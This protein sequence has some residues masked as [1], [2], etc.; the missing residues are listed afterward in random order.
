MLLM[1]NPKVPPV[2]KGELKRV[3]AEAAKVEE[4]RAKKGD[5][6]KFE[7][8]GK[9][10]FADPQGFAQECFFY[11]EGNGPAP[12]QL[13]ILGAIPEKKRVAV[14][15]GHGAGKCEAARAEIPLADGRVVKASDLVGK[16]FEIMA[17]AK[18]GSQYP[19]LAWA[20]DN[21]VE[22]VYRVVTEC[23]REILRTGNHPL[24][25][26]TLARGHGTTKWKKDR[27]TPAPSGFRP[28]SD[29]APGDLVAVPLHLHSVGNKPCPLDEVKLLGYLLGD[30]GT[31]SGVTFTQEEG[32]AKE[33][34]REIVGRLGSKCNE[35]TNVTIDVTKGHYSPKPNSVLTMVRF[36]GLIGKKS[37]DKRFP[38]WAWELPNSQLSVLLNR[39]FACDGWAYTRQEGKRGTSNIAIS[40]ASEGLIRD[41]ELALLRLGI[42]G[43]VR[44]RLVKSNTGKVFPCWEWSTRRPIDNIIFANIVGIFGKESAV[45]AVVKRSESSDV[46]RQQKW[47]QLGLPEGYE[48][49]RI[50]SVECVGEE[51]TVAITTIPDHT[52]VTTFVEHNSWTCSTAILWFAL[53]REAVGVDWK[54]VVTASVGTQLFRYLWPEVRSRARDLNWNLVG[55]PPFN[56]RNEL[57]MYSLQLQWGAAFCVAPE[58]PQKLEGAHSPNLAY[59]IDESKMVPD[60]IWDSVEGAFANAGPETKSEAFALAIST[61]GG[62]IGRFY[63]IHSRKS[64][65]ENWWCRRVTVEEAVAAGRVSAQWVEEKRRQWGADSSIFRSKCLAEFCSDDNDALIPLDWVTACMKGDEEEARGGD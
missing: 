24:L 34:F 55:R 61:P 7:E 57:L 6:K 19:A 42:T 9:R 33:E 39:L 37:K 46:K 8:F 38:E 5:R 25:S 58:E 16:S 45:S 1:P 15:S 4:E 27:L 59:M 32:P 11:P 56:M 65:F 21:G 26:G 40:L 36:W 63:D 64:G 2:D 23:G 44:K 3:A 60:A 41:V 52:F 17:F 20:S 54:C 18:D 10:Y 14:V 49:Q 50:R 62:P 22:T 47:Q 29:M 31:T 43:I 48:W 51:P 30:G 28:I 53:T 35:L 13:D 12:Y